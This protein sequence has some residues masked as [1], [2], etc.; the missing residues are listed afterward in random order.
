MH[1][2]DFIAL[3][4][5]VRAGPA[6]SDDLQRFLRAMW[7]AVRQH[8]HEPPTWVLFARIIGE[9][10]AGEAA[11]FDP[12]WQQY[13]RRGDIVELE[14]NTTLDDFEYLRTTL[15][16]LIVDFRSMQE[17]G[18]LD[19]PNL[20]PWDDP[21]SPSGNRWTNIHP[22]YFIEC[23]GAGTKAHAG[24]ELPDATWRQLGRWLLLGQIYE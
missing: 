16:Y 21:V 5:I 15:L 23:A 13:T 10:W 3:T 19:D 2:E 9:A 7:H 18:V 1:P 20:S 14:D 17:N 4:D 24:S 8:Q 22:D 12:A 11:P 6:P